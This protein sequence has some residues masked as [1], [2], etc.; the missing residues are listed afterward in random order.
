MMLRRS[1][2]SCCTCYF[3]NW[4]KGLMISEILAIYKLSLPTQSILWR[5]FITMHMAVG[6]KQHRLLAASTQA[7]GK[8]VQRT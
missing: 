5:P 1:S 3:F 8:L 6:C 4:S 2:R 7:C